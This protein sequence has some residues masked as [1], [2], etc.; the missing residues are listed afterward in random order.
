MAGKWTTEQMKSQAGKRAIVT[1]ANIGLGFQTARELARAGAQV[2]LAC[3]SLERGEA[4]AARIRVEQPVAQVFV[5]HLDL[6]SLDS[7]RAFAAEALA[8]RSTS[9]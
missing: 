8:A 7:V 5:A 4:A 9:W 3:R 6:S 1:G 2:V